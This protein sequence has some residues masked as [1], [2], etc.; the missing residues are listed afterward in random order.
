[1]WR[2]SPSRA[3]A[4]RMGLMRIEKRGGKGCRLSADA[5]IKMRPNG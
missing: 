5:Q 1:M 3:P 4:C 2:A